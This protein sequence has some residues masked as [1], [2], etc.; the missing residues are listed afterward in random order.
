M[1]KTEILAFAE[2]CHARAVIALL[3][4]KN[5][6]G[7]EFETSGQRYAYVAGMQSTLIEK[8]VNYIKTH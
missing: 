4:N 6:A 7:D 5:M 2:E 1:N 3:Q 8:L